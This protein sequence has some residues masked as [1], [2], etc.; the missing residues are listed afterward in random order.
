MAC[1]VG[2]IIVLFAFSIYYFMFIYH[3]D[4]GYQD[5]TYHDYLSAV[6]CLNNGDYDRARH[7]LEQSIKET[8][9]H[10]AAVGRPSDVQRDWQFARNLKL[11]GDTLVARRDYSLALG[12]YRRAKEIY[13]KLRTLWEDVPQIASELAETLKSLDVAAKGGGLN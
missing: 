13:E 6:T 1:A 12:Y 10:Y 5:N 11:L 7:I 3:T 9:R 4:P 2:V 8:E